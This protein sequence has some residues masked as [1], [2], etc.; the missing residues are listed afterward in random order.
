MGT[1]Y[2]TIST[3]S[4]AGV[5]AAGMGEGNIDGVE[6]PDSDAQNNV[7][8]SENSRK[9]I[10]RQIDEDQSIQVDYENQRFERIGL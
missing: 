5:T 10:K 6:D 9:L 4:G 8:R 7:R 3:D 2:S 1:R